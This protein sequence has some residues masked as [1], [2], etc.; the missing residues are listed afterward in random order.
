VD[1]VSTEKSRM[2]EPDPAANEATRRSSIGKR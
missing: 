2:N 1:V